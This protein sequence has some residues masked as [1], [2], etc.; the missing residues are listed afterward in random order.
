MK[1]LIFLL[2]AISLCFYSQ[3][4]GKIQAA[5]NL[6][7]T[8]A[9][10]IVNMDEV[11]GLATTKQ[12]LV[13][14]NAIPAN[15]RSVGMLVGVKDS[16]AIYTL[17]GGILDANWVKLLSTTSVPDNTITLTP[18]V[19]LTGI[20]TTVTVAHS[21]SGTPHIVSVEV[22]NA[23]GNSVIPAYADGTNVYLDFPIAPICTCTFTIRLT[24]PE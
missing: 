14:R 24:P 2:L 23:E 21:L 19:T 8:G 4:Q 13:E 18:T 12:S 1:Q 10:P 6:G 11:K 17:S 20:A 7:A 15:F 5:G 3:A 22:D 16:N 9:Y